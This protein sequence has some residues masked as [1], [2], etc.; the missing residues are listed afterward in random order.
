[1]TRRAGR[2][3]LLYRAPESTHPMRAATL[4]LFS[5]IRLNFEGKLAGY[6]T[7]SWAVNCEK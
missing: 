6:S 3:D 2:L 5:G 4:L 7:I 1:M